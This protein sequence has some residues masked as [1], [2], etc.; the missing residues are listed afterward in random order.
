[1]ILFNVQ[2]IFG[3]ILVKVQCWPATVMFEFFD[4]IRIL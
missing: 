2:S 1:M 3:G 4:C